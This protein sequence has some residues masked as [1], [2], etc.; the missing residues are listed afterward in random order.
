MRRYEAFVIGVIFMAAFFVMAS[1]AKALTIQEM[2]QGIEQKN[3]EI[4]KLQ[5]EKKKYQAELQKNQQKSGGLKQEIASIDSSIQSVSKTIA[6][7]QR[8][9]ER[10]QLQI[11]QLGVEISQK[12]SSIKKVKNGLADSVATFV[13]H[14]QEPLIYGLLRDTS[15]S[16]FF[17][18]LNEAALL[19]KNMLVTLGDLHQLREEQAVQKS[20]GEEKK[21]ELQGFENNL[22]TQKQSQVAIK[23]DRNNLLAVTKNQEKLYQQLIKEQEQKE[24]QLER[25]IEEFE[26]QIQVSINA[27]SLPAKGH[28]VLAY[29]LPDLVL[30]PCRLQF[31]AD[32]GNCITQYFGN[33]QFAA[34]GGYA[35]KG[36]NGMDFRALVGTPVLAAGA[37]TVEATGNTDS[38]CPRA[39]YGKWIL[40]R[41]NNNLSTVYGHLSG[42]DVASGQSVQRGQRIGLSGRTGYAT[43]PHLHISVVVSKAAQVTSLPAITCGKRR[44]I[45]LPIVGSDPVSGISGY[46]NPLNY[47]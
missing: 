19:Q 24:A 47:L 22:T 7:T 6:I 1:R 46:L 40:I 38:E 15:L 34:A 12:D 44:N 42:I 27:S 3:A 32:E 37:G 28:G 10:A 29:P 17:R 21:N 5:E 4:K 45:T 20:E 23:S 35:G 11:R 26:R 31:G 16:Q 8:Q 18:A 41:H 33:T 25:E 13:R 2:Q 9:I 39:S 14:E 43:G 30:Q 36:H